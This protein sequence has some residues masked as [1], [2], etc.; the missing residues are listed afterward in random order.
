[1][2]T[3]TTISLTGKMPVPVTVLSIPA[4]EVDWEGKPAVALFWADLA[5]HE[6]RDQAD[7]PQ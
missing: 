5:E 3:P 7:Q 4:V 1:M 6:D 2:T